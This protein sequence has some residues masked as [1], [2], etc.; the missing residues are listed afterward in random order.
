MSPH[1]VIMLCLALVLIRGVG[2]CC[3]VWSQ[4]CLIPKLLLPLVMFACPILSDL[5]LKM[6]S[7]ATGLVFS[8]L[9][10]IRQFRRFCLFFSKQL[11]MMGRTILEL[12]LWNPCHIHNWSLSL[13]LSLFS[14]RAWNYLNCSIEFWWRKGIG[15]CFVPAK[16]SIAE[17]SIVLLSKVDKL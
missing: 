2:T 17:G 16:N 13:E 1:T 15:M 4:N 3:Y 11:G 14:L 5:L 8:S 6:M 9:F 12:G 7:Y 10:L